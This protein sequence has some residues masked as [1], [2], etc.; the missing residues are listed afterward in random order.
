MDGS[1]YQG[2]G[3]YNKIYNILGID[4][5]RAC[6]CVDIESWWD[7]AHAWIGSSRACACVDIDNW[8]EHARVWHW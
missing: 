6:F 4:R 3:V 2:L 8:R 5:L 1:V 7:C